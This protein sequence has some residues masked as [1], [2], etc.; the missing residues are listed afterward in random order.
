M[1]APAVVRRELAETMA[2]RG[3]LVD[4]REEWIRDQAAA[5]AA[6]EVEQLRRERVPDG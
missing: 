2:M 3:I 4:S 6:R 5:K 1:T